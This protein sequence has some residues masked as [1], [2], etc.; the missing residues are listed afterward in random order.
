MAAKKLLIVESPAKAGTIKKYLGKDYNVLASMGHIIDLPKS[1]MGV[2]LENDFTPKYITIRG[3]G[4]LLSQLK[5]EAKK[6]DVVYLA[7]DP[8]REGEAI[9]WHLANA[10]N[11]DPQS[12]CRVTFN[13]ITK[14]AVKNA[15]KHP[16]KIDMDL[17][18]AQQAR[19]VL[20]RI[21]GYTISPILWEKVKRGLSAGRVQSVATKL[22]CD[23]EEEIEN[24]TPQEYWSLEAL[25][26]DPASKK[27][28]TAR[29][30]GEN[31]KETKLNNAAETKSVSDDL[32]NAKFI[33]E[34]VKK[35][36]QKRNPQP[37]FTTSTLQQDASRKYNFQA[38]KTM[39]IAQTLYEGVNLGGKIGSIGL[40]TYMRTDSLRISDDAQKEAVEYLTNEYG[41]EYV[42]PKQYRTKKS[43]QDAHEAIRPTSINI[44]P[45]D[46]KDKLTNDQY[47]LYKLI[48][49]RFAASQMA[50]AVYD[51]M[52]VTIDAG[53]H[54]F[55]AS[56]SNVKFK[57]YMTVYVESGEEK[58]KKEKMLPPLEEKSELKFKNLEEKQHFT[59]PPARYSDATLIRELEENGIGRP[60]TYAPTISTIVSRG[61]VARSKRQL[62]PTELGFVTSEIMKN[63]FSDIV[64]VEFTAGM[65][66]EL[67]SVE[68]GN[69][70]WKKVLNE[71]YP[72]FRDSLEKAQKNIEKI[73]IKDEES[74]VVCE[75]CGR[76]MVYKLSKFG[77]F[78][79]CP[80]YPEC[81]NTKAIREGTGVKCPKCDGEILVKK[82]RR[83]KVYYGCEHSPKCDFMAWYM[84][85]KDE[86]CPVCG[87]LL[88]KKTG[89]AGKIYCYN[90]DCKYERKAG[91][92]Q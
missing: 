92:K 74:D 77:K 5:K 34:N 81:K 29:Y 35:G 39:Q 63:N 24:F 30:Y 51:T 9:S 37:P 50:S 23:R 70:Q 82:S 86:V 6:A 56:G 65:E 75:K 62:V 87:G 66:E 89:R 83:G 25:L 85:V 21:V 27:D 8:D 13:E 16:R 19:R 1:Q 28:F 11:I 53:G 38:A 46:I 7:T 26:N 20:D 78:L 76:K 54:T 88:L 3:K 47:R 44:K 91:D 40:I 61:Y 73:K 84:P 72:S 22:I 58:E 68:E 69:I 31:G 80:G 49:E 90:E 42:N 43:A 52:Q 15:M 67:D 64:D 14:T 41:K 32:K 17:V 59:Q 60:S 45:I 36:Q 10:L 18:D 12:A 48:W 55:K 33:V 2:D 71:F 57:G 4:Q 79:A